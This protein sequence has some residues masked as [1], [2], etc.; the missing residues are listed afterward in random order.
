MAEIGI[1]ELKNRIGEVVRAVREERVEY[2]VTHRGRPVARLV[3]LA[4]EEGGEE[5][6]AELDRLSREVS[7]R[8]RS[9]L[10]AV[11]ILAEAR[12]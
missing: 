12:R 1:R 3:P 2:V 4:D 6:W 9:E 10:S 7:E 11:E 8:W 5:A